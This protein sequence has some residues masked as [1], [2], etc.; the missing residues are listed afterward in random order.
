MTFLVARN[1]NRQLDDLLQ[2]DFGRVPKKFL[3]SARTDS[4]T[5]NF[6]YCKLDPSFVFLVIQ[7]MFSS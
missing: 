1:E 5:K 7:R 2:V 6:V 4:K 3:L